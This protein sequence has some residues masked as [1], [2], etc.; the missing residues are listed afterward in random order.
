[1]ANCLSITKIVSVVGQESDECANVFDFNVGLHTPNMREKRRNRRMR[2]RR[3]RAQGKARVC[4]KR[5]LGWAKERRIE[6]AKKMWKI[7]I[8]DR[9]AM[10]MRYLG[11]VR[12]KSVSENDFV[13]LLC[14]LCVV[15]VAESK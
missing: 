2:R 10:A 7:G 14:T 13:A 11:T 5:K 1:M 6:T 8:R 12:R 9:C 4:D 15:S 3:R